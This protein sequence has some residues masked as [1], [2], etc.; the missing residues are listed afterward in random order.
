MLGLDVATGTVRWSEV[1]PPT[2]E[3]VHSNCIPSDGMPRRADFV[4]L[5]HCSAKDSGDDGFGYSLSGVSNGTSH[6]RSR[7]LVTG[8]TMIALTSPQKPNRLAAFDL[9]TGAKRWE[10]PAPGGGIVAAPLR[11]E[12]GQV[13]AVVSAGQTGPFS[14]S[15]GSTAGSPRH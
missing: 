6:R 14:E 7:A 5:S 3:K 2:D 13:I 9:R 15:A 4:L 8:T 11:V 1:T 12:G 10:A